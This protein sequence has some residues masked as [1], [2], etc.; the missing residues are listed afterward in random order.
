MEA[1]RFPAGPTVHRRVQPLEHGHAVEP[2]GHDRLRGVGDA[3]PHA[4]PMPRPP[5]AA[6]AAAPCLR[7]D[8]GGTGKVQCHDRL[9]GILPVRPALDD[10]TD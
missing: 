2:Q 10:A 4:D 1:L 6:A 3:Q 9:R 5:A 7:H 8:R